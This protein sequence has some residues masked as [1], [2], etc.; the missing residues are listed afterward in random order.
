MKNRIAKNRIAIVALS[1]AL[2]GC[3]TLME[4]LGFSAKQ[5]VLPDGGVGYAVQCVKGDPTRCYSLLGKACIQGYTV[6]EESESTRTRTVERDTSNDAIVE[7]DDVK[8]NISALLDDSEP[9]VITTIVHNMI[10]RCK[11]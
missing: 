9:Q 3:A 4:G 1:F 8:V 2:A 7:T 11:T 6:V 5:I 10:A